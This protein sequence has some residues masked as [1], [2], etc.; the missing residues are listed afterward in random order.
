MAPTGRR[1]S[2]EDD[3]SPSSPER[4]GLTSSP[5]ASK[6][7]LAR[8][9]SSKAGKAKRSSSWRSRWQQQEAPQEAEEEE[10]E[11]EEDGG[12]LTRARE[13]DS[14]VNQ[15]WYDARARVALQRMCRWLQV[16]WPKLVAFETMWAMQVR[17]R[18]L[19]AGDCWCWCW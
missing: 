15:R 6:A 3:E 12:L 16:P 14:L 4:R 10:E 13:G 1:G 2:Y 8:S 5:T 19:G 17:C 11:E 18:L 9:A 7:G